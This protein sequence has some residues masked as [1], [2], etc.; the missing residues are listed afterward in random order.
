MVYRRKRSYR[1]KRVFKRRLRRRFIRR[2]NN[3]VLFTKMKQM[4]EL[5]T[6]PQFGNSDIMFNEAMLGGQLWNSTATSDGTQAQQWNAYAQ[7]YGKFK[8]L[9]L[10]IK[11]IPIVNTALPTQQTDTG[12]QQMTSLASFS[13]A[14]TYCTYKN[15]SLGHTSGV[16]LGEALKQKDSIT[17][18]AYRT[19]SVYYRWV[20]NLLSY[21]NNNNVTFGQFDSLGY[22][23][24][25]PA[26]SMFGEQSQH[27]GC[28]A[29]S[30]MPMY[31]VLTWYIRFKD[32]RYLPPPPT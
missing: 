2:K 19:K 13:Q 28:F 11:F 31:A 9:G 12:N 27:V 1:R 14:N 26:A 6:I 8:I 7:I 16:N 29:T 18:N 20:N 25:V 24:M 22:R 30:G 21:D 17:W 3:N 4:I 32:K 15:N 10:R 5:S 23:N